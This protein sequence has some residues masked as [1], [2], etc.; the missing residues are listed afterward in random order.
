MPRYIL[1]ESNSGYIWGDT[2]DVGGK[3]LELG[4]DD[5]ALM[6]AC[7]AVDDDCG[8]P[9]RTYNVISNRNPRALQGQDG[10]LV[11]RAPDDFRAVPDGQNQDDIE[12]VERECTLVGVVQ[13]ED[14][15][16]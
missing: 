10:Y 12:A 9:D 1:I 14:I 11:Y 6:Q 5:T 8:A 2:S 4:T 16:C 15:E 13:V 7:A 3:N